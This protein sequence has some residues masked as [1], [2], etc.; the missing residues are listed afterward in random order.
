MQQ[1]VLPLQS[2]AL[3][4][5]KRSE[6]RE[7]DGK[8][9]IDSS[10]RRIREACQILRDLLMADSCAPLLVGTIEERINRIVL[11]LDQCAGLQELYE[12]CVA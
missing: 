6:S 8:A 5:G 12:K 2:A 7:S 1:R 10:A 11:A 3:D 9:G 4:A